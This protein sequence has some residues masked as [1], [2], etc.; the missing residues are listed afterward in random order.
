MTSLRVL[1]VTLKVI[2][3]VTVVATQQVLAVLVQI[4]HQNRPRRTVL[5]QVAP[6]TVMVH[7]VPVTLV[8]VVAIQQVHVVLVQFAH[9]NRPRRTVL[10]QVAPTTVM[11]HYVVAIHVMHQQVLAVLVQVAR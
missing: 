8:V 5:L 10:L 4:A 11:V 7:C 3:N 6:T 1:R 2:S 9:Q